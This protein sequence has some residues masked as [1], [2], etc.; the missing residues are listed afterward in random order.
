MTVLTQSEPEL[1]EAFFVGSF[2]CGLA[3]FVGGAGRVVYE[4][5]WI[6][7]RCATKRPRWPLWL[8]IE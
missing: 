4:A 1:E 2:R 6:G 5:D 3:P 8:W 7:R